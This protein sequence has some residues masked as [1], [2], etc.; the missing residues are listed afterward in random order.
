MKNITY[1]NKNKKLP[2]K[3]SVWKQDKDVK[4]SAVLH[5]KNN[6]LETARKF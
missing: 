6:Q 3:S 2:G 1:K 5:T 4:A